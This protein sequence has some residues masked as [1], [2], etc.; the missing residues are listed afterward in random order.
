MIFNFQMSFTFQAMG[1]GKQ[2]LILSSMRQ[3]LVNIPLL[4][5]M[6]SVFG[7]YGVVWTQFFADSITGTISYLVYRKSYNRLLKRA[8]LLENTKEQNADTSAKTE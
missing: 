5:I 2:S 1:M 8:G 6:N 4:L 7:L 3:G